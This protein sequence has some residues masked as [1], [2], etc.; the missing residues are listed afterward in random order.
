MGEVAE[1]FD[2]NPSLLRYWEQEFDILKPHR[3]KKGNRLF[4]PKDVDNIRIIYHL[5]KERKMKIE[6]ARKYIRD[7]R[8]EVDRDAEITEHLMNIRAI[9]LEIKQDL[10]YGGAVVDDDCDEEPV[11][12]PQQSGRETV[13]KGDEAGE[14][15]TRT[16]TGTAAAADRAPESAA[17]PTGETRERAERPAPATAD[18]R[19]PFEEQVLFEVAVPL[20]LMQAG[21]TADDDGFESARAAFAGETAGEETRRKR[22]L[23]RGYRPS[24]RPCSDTETAGRTACTGQRRTSDRILFRQSEPTMKVKEI[25]AILE[26]A[27]PLFLQENYDNSGLLVGDPEA[28]IDSALICV[29]ATESVVAEAAEVGAG[30]VLSHHPVI[31]HPLKRLTGGQLHRTHGGRSR[32]PRHRALRLPHQPRQR[33]GGHEP[34]VG[35]SSGTAER[36]TSRTHRHGD[37]RFGIRNRRRTG[38]RA[39]DGGV[40]ADCTRQA[41]SQVHKVQRHHA[42]DGSARSPLHRSRSLHDVRRQT[43]GSRRLPLGGF[44]IQRLPRCRPRTRDCRHRTF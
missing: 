41:L 28:E 44:Q 30:L 33:P 37:A 18:T 23:N 9:L 31:F 40:S 14:T 35:Q 25:T 11:A 1:M 43:G 10:A 22:S 8:K 6:V 13:G 3:N 27:A 4:T 34:D 2:V 29:D 15:D 36:Y 16:K 17:Q 42:A 21:R 7:Y 5:L 19:P 32:T 38:T 26:E 12:V 39:A 20:E 24:N